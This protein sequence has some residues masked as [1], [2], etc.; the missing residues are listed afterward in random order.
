MSK[1]SAFNYKA[2]TKLIHWKRIRIFPVSQQKIKVD[3]PVDCGN[4]TKAIQFDGPICESVT[5]RT[6]SFLCCTS[7]KFAKISRFTRQKCR[8][9]VK[10]TYLVL[11]WGQMKITNEKLGWLL[12]EYV[13]LC[14]HMALMRA[15]VHACVDNNNNAE[16]S[17][18]N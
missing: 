5:K 7:S 13:N 16:P 17:A 6:V 1:Q 15:H 14:H 9:Q 2:S 3:A 4:K 10:R 18:L 11:P 12:N 8:L